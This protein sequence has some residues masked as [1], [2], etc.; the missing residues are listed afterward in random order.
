MHVLKIGIIFASQGLQPTSPLKEERRQI[1]TSKRRR[2]G[3][4]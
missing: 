1:I 3:R 4:L 2:G